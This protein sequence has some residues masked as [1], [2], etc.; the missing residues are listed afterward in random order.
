MTILNLLLQ[1][2]V[3]AWDEL[4]K[5]GLLFLMM[6]IAIFWLARKLEKKETQ[7][8]EKNKYIQT[9]AENSIA[10]LKDVQSTMDKV[11]D[12]QV[13]G[14]QE[15]TKEIMDNCLQVQNNLADMI[16]DLKRHLPIKSDEIPA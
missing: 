9:M 15:L 3:T 5:A 11:F 10:T 8:E 12:N 1:A 14:S 13:A 7:L 16:K 6:G 2:P 4:A